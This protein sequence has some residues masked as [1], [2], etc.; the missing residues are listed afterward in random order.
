MPISRVQAFASSIGQTDLFIDAL[1]GFA[2]DASRLAVEEPQLAAPFT[3]IRYGF[4]VIADAWEGRA[5]DASISRAITPRVVAAVTQALESPSTDS[6][7]ELA[8]ALTWASSYPLH[9]RP[10]RA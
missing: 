9:G 2:K 8:E 6:W 5:L 4:H 3:L 1:R 7:N 10:V